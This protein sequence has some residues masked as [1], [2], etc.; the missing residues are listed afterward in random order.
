M[1]FSWVERQDFT[2]WLQLKCLCNFINI[3]TVSTVVTVSMRAPVASSLFLRVILYLYGSNKLTVIVYSYSPFY[4]VNSSLCTAT[5][6]SVQLD[7]SRCQVCL[8]QNKELQ[9]LEASLLRTLHGIFWK[10][11]TR[12][13]GH[14]VYCCHCLDDILQNG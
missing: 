1:A 9:G 13:F 2:F 6:P 12:C 3:G 10:I 4:F 7:L 11:L 14:A 8:D 5:L